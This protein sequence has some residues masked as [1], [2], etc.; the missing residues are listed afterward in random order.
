MKVKRE[1]L[2]ES[3]N[4][5]LRQVA[6]EIPVAEIS[7]ATIQELISDMRKLLAKEEYGVALAA[8]QVGEPL[9]LFIVSGRAIARGSRNA[10]DEIGSANADDGR[11]PPA[12]GGSALGR[13]QVYINPVMTKLSRQKSE[14]HEGCLSVRGKWGEVLRSEKATIQ[15]FDEDGR[16]FT[17]GASGFLAHIF[18]HEM[19]HLEGVLYTDKAAHMYDEQPANGK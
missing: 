14:K 19:D 3:A 8:P 7:G 16:R 10:P 5:A 12:Q 1:I 9:R 6:R 18:Q 15:A 4:G 13:D 2:P 17:R 11:V